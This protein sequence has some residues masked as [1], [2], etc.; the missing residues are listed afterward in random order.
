MSAS[1]PSHTPLTPDDIAFLTSLANALKS[2]DTVST[3]KPVIYQ[4]L[5]RQFHRVVRILSP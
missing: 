1:D 5:Q 3:A 2:Q 4:I